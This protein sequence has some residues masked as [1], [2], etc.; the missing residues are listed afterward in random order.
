[1]EFWCSFGFHRNNKMVIGD[2]T[3]AS[4][5]Y[6]LSNRNTWGVHVCI[7][8]EQCTSSHP[9]ISLDWLI[10]TSER[11]FRVHLT[12]PPAPPPG[13][14]NRQWQWSCSHRHD[15]SVHSH[16]FADKCLVIP[17][18]SLVMRHWAS[19]SKSVD[20]ADAVV[21]AVA[22]AAVIMD[23]YQGRGRTSKGKESKR[24]MGGRRMP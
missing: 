8:K 24:R 15:W 10:I 14:V 20:A 17:D 6:C 9:Y 2:D 18:F 19:L 7:R 13:P 21:A 3:G 16:I 23:F 1:M 5:L 12:S 22:V 4:Q 11:T